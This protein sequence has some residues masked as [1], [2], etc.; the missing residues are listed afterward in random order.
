MQYASFNF[1]SKFF[2]KYWNSYENKFCACASNNKHNMSI[3][4]RSDPSKCSR[5]TRDNAKG[6]VSHALDASDF[7]FK[8]SSEHEKLDTSY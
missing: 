3:L 5:H 7:G 4:K 6:L 8:L 1:D 2:L